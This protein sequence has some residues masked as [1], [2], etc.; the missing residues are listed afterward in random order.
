[1]AHFDF[2]LNDF[3][4]GKNISNAIIGGTKSYTPT[5]EAKW[6]KTTYSMVDAK[7]QQSLT[8][9][10]V[11]DI[12]QGNLLLKPVAL[13]Y[14]QFNEVTS[15]ISKVANTTKV[16]DKVGALGY[17]K[18]LAGFDT[19]GAV[20]SLINHNIN[21]TTSPN[22]I[23]PTSP[24]PTGASSIRPIAGGYYLINHP[25]ASPQF[26]ESRNNGLSGGVVLHTT[27][28]GGGYQSAEATAA[29]IS[30]RSDP[31]SYHCIVDSEPNTAV[32][33]M[34]DNYTAFGVATPGFNSRC[35]NIAIAANSADLNP[36]SPETLTEIDNMGREIVAFW[37]RNSID[38]TQG[39]R[40]I[41]NGVKDGPGLA[42]HGDVQ[43]GDRSDAWA[44]REDRELFDA[45]LL[46][47]IARHAIQVG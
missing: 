26:H 33:M 28:G 41:G 3:T 24:S 46:Q 1:M 21:T 44:R 27:E 45:L 15:N 8:T 40:F 17:R 7:A 12:L 9:A 42:H 20:N 19:V 10:S 37:A 31:G 5:G 13:N 23:T 47:A 18:Y 34:P 30:R 39:V 11:S 38:P 25:P 43:P 35:W 32:Y 14:T 16:Q 2:S 29:F 4:N 36:S 22:S 6:L